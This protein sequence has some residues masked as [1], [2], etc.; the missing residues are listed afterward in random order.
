MEIILN[1]QA[2]PIDAAYTVGQLVSELFPSGK[3]IAV[4]IN[5][6]VVPKSDWP[7]RRLSPNDQVTLIT[8][9]QGG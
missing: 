9:T 3:G 4:A 6:A 7:T 1:G 5:Q 2:K 8:A